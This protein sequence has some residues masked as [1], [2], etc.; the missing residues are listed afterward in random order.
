MS[1]RTRGEGPNHQGD[2]PTWVRHL[3]AAEDI[4]LQVHRSLC[5]THPGHHLDLRPTAVLDP[6]AL[7]AAHHPSA[8]TPVT[9]QRT[10]L[11]AAAAP[12]LDPSPRLHLGVQL[13]QEI[14]RT[15]QTLP[16]AQKVSR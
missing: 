16:Q 3:E 5:P 14:Q 2:V 10:A 4:A 15:D 13:L 6:L 11:S 1:G 12:G 8:P 9:L 7:E